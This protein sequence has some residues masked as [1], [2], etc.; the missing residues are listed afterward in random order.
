MH[1]R[2]ADPAEIDHLAGIWYDGWQDAHAGILPLELARRRTL[3]SFR[4]RL[5]ADL[6]N[7]RVVGAVFRP[8]GFCLVR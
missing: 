7:L 6:E 3:D 2:P 4:Q 1:V 8:V 5:R